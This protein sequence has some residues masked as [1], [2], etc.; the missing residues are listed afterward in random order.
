[1]Y[2]YGVKFVI[3]CSFCVLDIVVVVIGGGGGGGVTVVV[4]DND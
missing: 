1:M 4:V 2:L 3:V